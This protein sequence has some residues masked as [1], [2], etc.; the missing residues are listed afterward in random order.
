MVR[1]A[2]G[3]VTKTMEN[4]EDVLVGVYA[5]LLMDRWFKSPSGA[6]RRNPLPNNRSI[7]T[8]RTWALVYQ[9]RGRILRYYLLFVDTKRTWGLPSS[10]SWLDVGGEMARLQGRT[11]SRGAFPLRGPLPFST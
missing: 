6:N 5:N 9:F 7:A 10:V 11:Q 4:K 3:A 2:H 8:K 1:A